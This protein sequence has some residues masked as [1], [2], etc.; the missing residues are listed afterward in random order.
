MGV[1][2]ESAFWRGRVEMSKRMTQFSQKLVTRFKRAR[3]D[4]AW[5][6]RLFGIQL[7]LIAQPDKQHINV[8]ILYIP[9]LRI[10]CEPTKFGINLLVLTW[11]FKAVK[12]AFTKWRIIQTKSEMRIVFCGFNVYQRQDVAPYKFPSAQFRN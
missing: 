6:L 9:F 8:F 5:E 4:K 11:L 10:D 12:Y 7:F 2:A 1:F 3:G